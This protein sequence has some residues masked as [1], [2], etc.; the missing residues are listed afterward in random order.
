MKNAVDV[1]GDDDA[2]AFGWRPLG[3]NLFYFILFYFA[4]YDH[5]LGTDGWILPIALTRC[6]WQSV[7]IATKATWAG[8]YVPTS[9]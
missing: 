6:Q 2:G 8:K 9:L 3:K 1:I 5:Q 4:R 7:L